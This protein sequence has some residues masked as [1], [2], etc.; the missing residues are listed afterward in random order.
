M[1]EEE[2]AKED[3]DDTINIPENFINEN[4]K[5]FIFVRFPFLILIRVKNQ[6]SA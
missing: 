5:N 1:D 3:I 4:E 6:L 2:E